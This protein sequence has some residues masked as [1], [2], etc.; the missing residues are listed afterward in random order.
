MFLYRPKCVVFVFLAYSV[1]AGACVVS[2]QDPTITAISSDDLPPG[3]TALEDSDCDG[4]PDE[5]DP[6]P[7]DNADAC[8]E[9]V[10]VT[11]TR[12]PSPPPPRVPAPSPPTP[13]TLLLPPPSPQPPA[14]QTPQQI[15]DGMAKCILDNLST[16]DWG[17]ATPHKV[18]IL[19]RPRVGGE[20]VDGYGGCVRGTR[21]VTY[22][23]KS[24]AERGGMSLRIVMAHEIAHHLNTNRETCGSKDGREHG[25]GFEGAL[26]RA[27]TAAEG[28]N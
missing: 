1:P 7:N 8:V 26:G 17:E 22:V 2:E 12:P 4:V 18:E 15:A 11:G 27:R 13:P 23:K 6:C 3:H 14:P 9:T 16:E 24:V 28:C 25:S 5:T 20:D 21:Y 10:T 19:L